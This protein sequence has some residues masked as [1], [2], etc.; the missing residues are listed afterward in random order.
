MVNLNGKNLIKFYNSLIVA[1]IVD[2][3]EDF[4]EKAKDPETV[5]QVLSQMTVNSEMESNDHIIAF[6]EGLPFFEPS[7][8]HSASSLFL[9]WFKKIVNK[10]SI[11][12]G[13]AVQASAMGLSGYEEDGSLKYIANKNNTNILE[14][15]CEIPWDLNYTDVNGNNIVL[16]YNTYCKP[17]GNL[18]LSNVVDTEGKFS[19]F[20]GEDGK[21]SY[22]PLIELDYPN[23]TSLLAYRIPT[24]NHYSMINLRVKRFSNKTTGGVIKVPPQGTVIAGFDFDIDKLFLMRYEFKDKKMT[25]KQIEQVWRDIYTQ[26]PQVMKTLE[27]AREKSGKRKEKLYTFWEEAGLKGTS[28]EFFRNHLEQNKGKY[29]T[30]IQYDYTKSPA[31]N[32]RMARNN[33]LIQLIQERL[34]DENTFS[35]RYTPGGFANP[36]IAAKKMRLLIFG[37]EELDNKNLK[38]DTYNF[39]DIEDNSKSYEDPEPNYDI[40]DPMTMVEYT[41]QNNIAGDLI[42]IFA[43]HNANHAI[44]TLLDTFHLKEPIIFGSFINAKS[45]Y[46]LGGDLL[47]KEVTLANGR[48]INSALSLAEF[49]S[50]SVDAVKDPVLNFLNLN[51]VTADS[52]AMLARLG[53]S[54]E[55]IGLLLNQPVI[56]ALCEAILL[57]ML[58][59][60]YRLTP[61]CAYDPYR[62]LI[63]CYQF[64]QIHYF[65]SLYMISECIQCWSVWT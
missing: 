61:I 42:G 4:L 30:F 55:D 12:G 54:I 6:A 8:E 18:I 19:T 60:T 48:V 62:L 15:E 38:G 29:T 9:S 51:T 20:L 26:H 13:S 5:K 14:V 11:K 7:L 25:Q 21:T 28:E 32:D 27:I 2:S 23:I 58:E 46:E 36:S 64:I 53:Y 34:K 47:T 3:Y 56:K 40:F 17:D 24:E 1:N 39:A 37:N 31:A 57:A 16:D 44:S 35:E 50:A 33:M 41:M 22:I 65:N 63:S 10:Q 45:D 59:I 49:L 43:N 52:A